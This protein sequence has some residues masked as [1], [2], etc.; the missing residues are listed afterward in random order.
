MFG[1]CDG[2][3]VPHQLNYEN[4][5]IFFIEFI[6][7]GNLYSYDKLV[8]NCLKQLLNLKFYFIIINFTFT[9]F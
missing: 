5:I 8:F 9:L 6:F 3:A 1:L 4:P 7:K 2:T